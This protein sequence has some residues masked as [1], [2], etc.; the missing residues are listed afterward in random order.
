MRTRKKPSKRSLVKKLQSGGTGDPK[1]PVVTQ[2]AAGF[3]LFKEDGKLTATPVSS[4]YTKT[5]QQGYYEGVPILLPE[6]E[7]V[8]DSGD[9]LGSV[10]KV[11]EERGG[12]I[13]GDYAA[14]PVGEREKF[15]D[16]VR[17]AIGE[18]AT[19]AAI[20]MA[21]LIAMAGPSVLASGLRGFGALYEIPLVQLSGVP[22]LGELSLPTSVSVGTTLDVVGAG[23]ATLEQQFTTLLSD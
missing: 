21:P 22:A 20:A 14:L 17:D 18:G 7:V 12:G 10:D 13:F 16:G 15:E 19:I 2:S 6:A 9:A 8:A 1:K 4:F 23:V 11:V 5:N 3:P